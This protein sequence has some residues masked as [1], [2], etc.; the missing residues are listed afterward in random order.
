[1][2]RLSKRH[3]HGVPHFTTVTGIQFLPPLIQKRQRLLSVSRLVAQI[4]GHT[5][6]SVNR[7]KMRPQTL[8]QKPRSNVEVLVVRLC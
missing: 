3:K 5:A 4:I 2:D 8:R 6:I 1:M 7:M